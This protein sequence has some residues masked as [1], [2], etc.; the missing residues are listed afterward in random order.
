MIDLE[1][2]ARA[3]CA[4]LEPLGLTCYPWTDGAEH[5][6]SITVEPDQPWVEYDRSFGASGYAATNWRLTVR[7]SLGAGIDEAYARM[8]AL[9]GTDAALSIFDALRADATLGGAVGDC[10]AGRVSAPRREMT[11]QGEVLTMVYPVTIMERRG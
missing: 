10:H 6:D 1:A 3:L 11:D 8:Y 4:Q 9:C 5:P 7:L 2:Q